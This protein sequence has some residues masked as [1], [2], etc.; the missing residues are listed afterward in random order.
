MK[1][2]RLSK[3]L[4]ALAGYNGFLSRIEKVFFKIKVSFH[5]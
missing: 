1:I 5:G 4:M 3:N 2:E